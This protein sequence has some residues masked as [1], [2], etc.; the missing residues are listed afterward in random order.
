MI[1][2]GNPET[3]AIVEVARTM[4]LRAIVVDP[5]PGSPAKRHATRAYDIDVKD[6]LAL[7]TVVAAER[8]EGILVGVADPIVPYYQQLCARYGLP[9]YASSEIIAA[10]N[11]KASFAQACADYGVR[12]TPQFRV[13][14]AT[15]QGLDEIVYPAVVKPVDCGAGVGISVCRDRDAC[16]EGLR[17]ALAA[18]PRKQVVVERFMDCDDMF[19]YYTFVDG[20]AHLSAT[21]DRYKTEQQAGLSPVCIG[22]EYPSRHTARFVDEVHPRL[23]DMFTGLGIRHG[24]LLIQFFV[25]AGGFYAYDPG[26]RLQ[27]EAPHLYLKHFNGFDQREMMIR[28]AMTGS[29]YAG[30]FE[31]VNDY[32]FDGRRATTFWILLRAGQIGHVEGIERI[33]AMPGVI[34]VVHRLDVGDVITDAMTGTERQVFARIYTVQEHGGESAAVAQSLRANLQVRDA[35][36]AD[37][38]LDMYAPEVPQ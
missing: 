4:G 16:I 37:L 18:S 9:C 24:V 22:A 38:V 36:G 1:L 17:K 27:G 7:D 34:A 13:N 25:D 33:A 6:F 10:L 23:L 8:V 28:F 26:F 12:T 14:A 30:N 11:S 32:R 3:G 29:M 31:A 5:Y 20:R 15:L 2:G 35:A 19:A 21:A